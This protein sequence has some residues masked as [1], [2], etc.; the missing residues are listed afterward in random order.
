MGSNSNGDPMRITY[1]A[2]AA[3]ALT[4]AA[5]GQS[6]TDW[7][8]YGKDPAGTRY[9]PLKQITPKNVG[10]LTRAWT[11]H[12]SVPN[13]APAPTAGENSAEGAPAPAPGRRGRGGRGGGGA[14]A[15]EVSPLIVN[16]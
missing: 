11:Y 5:F 2:V 8:T 14:R 6:P 10:T 7:P 9:S 12:M 15:S 4:A 1:T 13:A 16:G 3:A